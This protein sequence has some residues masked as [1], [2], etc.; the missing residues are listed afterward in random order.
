MA[1]SRRG[2]VRRHLA[3]PAAADES[4]HEPSWQCLSLGAPVDIRCEVSGIFE[5]NPLVK[6][7]LLD[8]DGIRVG[9]VTEQ[10]LQGKSLAGLDGASSL[11]SA[12]G[13]RRSRVLPAQCSGRPVSIS[14]GFIGPA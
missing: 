3:G 10:R 14:Q 1:D 2:L 5:A 7:E 12:E 11:F 8:A 6:C 4:A 13:P 9:A